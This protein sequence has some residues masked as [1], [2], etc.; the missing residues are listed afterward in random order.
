MKK[1]LK[2]IGSKISPL[3]LPENV[4]RF[5]PSRDFKVGGGNT[6]RVNK[7]GIHRLF[8]VAS[9]DTGLGFRNQ[10]WGYESDT[11]IMASLNRFVSIAMCNMPNYDK[12][13]INFNNSY[14]NKIIKEISD[15]VEKNTC[16]FQNENALDAKTTIKL[17]I[18][19]HAYP[20]VRV[21]KTSSIY[22]DDQKVWCYQDQG[23][24]T[25]PIDRMPTDFDDFDSMK[26]TSVRHDLGTIEVPAD[27]YCFFNM[28][29]NNYTNCGL[30]FCGEESV[31]WYEERAAKIQKKFLPHA[32]G[33]ETYVGYMSGANF[34]TY[35]KNNNPLE[36]QI[37]ISPSVKL[38]YGRDNPRIYP[39][40]QFDDNKHY[41]LDCD[42]DYISGL[43]KFDPNSNYR[44]YA[45]TYGPEHAAELAKLKFP[46]LQQMF[47]NKPIF[48]YY[49]P[50][51]QCWT[52]PK[53]SPIS[54]DEVCLK[55]L[56]M[57]ERQYG[58]NY[59]L[60]TLK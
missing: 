53:N 43:H 29:W 10:F 17:T 12:T 50:D 5:V 35:F 30:E 39:H 8:V 49:H 40:L 60:I 42:I 45:P 11:N 55:S 24:Q 51:E 9:Y 47:A 13:D 21:A 58:I 48:R 7:F 57:Y 59:D 41:Y 44:L 22:V 2:L 36:L 25:T 14:E 1:T 37:T 20:Q 18:I 33:G 6:I 46:Q 54:Y 34:E 23:I 38:G 16:Q 56:W 32:P 27:Q 19:N 4:N 28:M 52:L 15:H 3:I 26:T 31:Q